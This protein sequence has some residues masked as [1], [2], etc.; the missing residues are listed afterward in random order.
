MLPTAA[1]GGAISASVETARK[2][3]VCTP[4]RL[5]ISD[6]SGPVSRLP[7]LPR[8]SSSASLWAAA[9]CAPLFAAAAPGAACSR[10]LEVPALPRPKRGTLPRAVPSVDA[11][12]ARL[13]PAPPKSFDEP[14]VAAA[15]EAPSSVAAEP[16]RPAFAAIEPA[17]LSFAPYLPPSS[18]AERSIVLPPPPVDA[19]DVIRDASE[20]ATDCSASVARVL[21]SGADF[22]EMPCD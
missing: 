22:S 21:G 18:V 12:V 20:P 8:S 11:S 16:R 7:R 17:I 19:G 1:T 10:S 13:A 15:H 14:I 4:I 5:S 2:V 3:R 6:V 9:R